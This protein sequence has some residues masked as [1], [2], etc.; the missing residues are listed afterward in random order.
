[1]TL[2][3]IGIV[4][5]ILSTIVATVLSMT[6]NMEGYELGALFN[7]F[8]PAFVGILVNLFAFEKQEY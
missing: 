7:L 6:V 2:K 3:A 1:M 5:I 8:L 4:A